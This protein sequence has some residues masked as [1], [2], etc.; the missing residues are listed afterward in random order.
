MVKRFLRFGSELVANT[1]LV[2]GAKPRARFTGSAAVPLSLGIVQAWYDF[3]NINSYVT[4]DQGVTQLKDLSGNSVDLTATNLSTSGATISAADTQFNGLD[5]LEL[6]KN[7]SDR[8][9][10]TSSDLPQIAV[11]FIIA[12]IRRTHLSPFSMF[13]TFDVPNYQGATFD[14]FGPG[15]V[16]SGQ[17]ALPTEVFVNGQQLTESQY[18][19]GL[20]E[21]YGGANEWPVDIVETQIVALTTN[22]GNGSGTPGVTTHDDFIVSQGQKLPVEVKVFIGELIV[23]NQVPNAAQRQSLEGYLATKWGVTL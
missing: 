23:L 6:F 7:T 1:P 5:T 3:S 4:G 9:F 11:A 8:R 20:P 18:S 22:P 21:T 16:E 2:V 17:F 13:S 10:E 14:F 12:V 19:E 15:F